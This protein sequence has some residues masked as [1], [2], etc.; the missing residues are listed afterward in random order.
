MTAFSDLPKK[1]FIRLGAV[2]VLAFGASAC[3][4]VPDW[5]DPT[6]WIGGDNSQASAPPPAQTADNG[7]GQAST[8]NGNGQTP[9]LSTIPEKP[10]APSNADE[11]KAVS[12]SLAADRSQAQY[13]ADALKGGTEPSAAPPPAAGPTDQS[14]EVAAG[15]S[16]SS[17]ENTGDESQTANAPS[18]PAPI[19]SAPGTLPADNSP[20][21]QEA[22]TAPP[23]ESAAPAPA[24]AASNAPPAPNTQIASAET[25]APAATT[26]A[27]AAVPAVAQTGPQITTS[28]ATLGF[29][30]SSAPPLD[31]SVAQFVPAPILARYSQTAAIAPPAA[32]P[33]ASVLAATSGTGESDQTTTHHRHAHGAA[34]GIGG[35]EAMSGAV[36]ANFDAL[37]GGAS[38]ATI[39]GAGQAGPA[40]VVFFSNDTTVL[41]ADA[42]AQVRAAAQAYLARGSQGYIRVVG[43]SSSKAT[44]MSASRQVVW[45]FERS[46][47]RANAVARELIRQ[48]VPA[49]KVLVVGA[50]DSQP[51]YFESTPPGQDSN[52]SAEIFFQ[53]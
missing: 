47:A 40:A 22:Q 16:G 43:H 34:M 27:E 10:E 15:E 11:Q 14:E 13:S 2:L 35:P 51:V 45:N 33:T 52:R 50:G 24:P 36:V 29:H 5:V 48:G 18:K 1:L 49:D 4:S 3:S 6:T 17:D 25:A 19:T 9:D 44:S 23:A 12:D 42:K 26:S 30:P 39:Q 53:G 32:V 20:A 37:Q 31:P 38:A 8:D 28:D 21:P 41:G 7:N 46:Q